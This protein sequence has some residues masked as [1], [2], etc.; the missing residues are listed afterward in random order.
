MRP[1]VV[2]GFAVVVA[3]ASTVRNAHASCDRLWLQADLGVPSA[4][5]LLLKR[6]CDGQTL[7][8]GVSGHRQSF[9]NSY[10]DRITGAENPDVKLLSVMKVW[11]IP[12]KWGYVDASAGL[13]Y[14]RGEW[15]RNCEDAPRGWFSIY[16]SY[17]CDF[18]KVSSFAV[19][20][21]AT[22]V[23]GKY[24]GIGVNLNLVI[25]FEGVS[26]VSTGFSVPI[27]DFTL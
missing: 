4:V 2:F 23:L 27:G 21:Q 14:M 12:Y 3:L 1:L 6:E 8:L 15:G 11:D 20:M 24:L 25:G 19:P 18:E 7:A 22:A 26:F 13:G 10:T 16:P 17:V 9:L 5:G